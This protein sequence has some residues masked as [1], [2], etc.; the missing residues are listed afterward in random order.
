M[1]LNHYIL[2]LLIISILCAQGATLIANEGEKKDIIYLKDGT[3]LECDKINTGFYLTDPSFYSISPYIS[4]DE[5]NV[6]YEKIEKIIYADGS[7]KS[8][9]EMI[10]SR[11]KIKFWYYAT[12]TSIIVGLTLLAS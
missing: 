2:V 10:T 5:Q 12:L 1:S 7:I 4:C 3:F 9:G 8:G 11:N 6:E